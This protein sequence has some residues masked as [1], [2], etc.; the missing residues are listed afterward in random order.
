MAHKEVRLKDLQDSDFPIT[1][2]RPGVVVT[3]GNASMLKSHREYLKYIECDEESLV[4]VTEQ[5]ARPPMPSGT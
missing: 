4:D 2:T 3:L 5:K 1:I